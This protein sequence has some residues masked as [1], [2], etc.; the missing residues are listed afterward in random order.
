MSH[1]VEIKNLTKE[2]RNTYLQR[3]FVHGGINWSR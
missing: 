3:F 2:I 1:V